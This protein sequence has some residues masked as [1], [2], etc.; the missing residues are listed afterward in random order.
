[1]QE[2][3]NVS[4]GVQP[5]LAVKGLIDPILTKLGFSIYIP[6]CCLGSDI[7]AAKPTFSPPMG[8]RNSGAAGCEPCIRKVS[9]SAA[10]AAL[11][12]AES[13]VIVSGS[14]EEVCMPAPKSI[15]GGLPVGGAKSLNVRV[16]AGSVIV[17]SLFT[18]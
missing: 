14:P 5:L 10:V 3:V 1:M 12:V 11:S 2:R 8:S 18:R 15:A 17:V 9:V 13:S 7:K 6:I 16:V 4:D